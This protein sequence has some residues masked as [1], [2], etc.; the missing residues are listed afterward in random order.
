MSQTACAG[1]GDNISVK[2]AIHK[3]IA[4]RANSFF[5]S[6][7]IF[8]IPS[9]NILQIFEG[10][11]PDIAESPPAKRSE[12]CLKEPLDKLFMTC[13]FCVLCWIAL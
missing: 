6:I 7:F 3:P 8:K 4:Q 2:A 5:V 13:S 10:G 11:S 12:T 1:D 9:Q